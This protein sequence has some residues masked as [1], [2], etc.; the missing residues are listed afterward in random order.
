MTISTHLE[1]PLGELL[2]TSHGEKLTGLYFADSPHAPKIAPGWIE[3]EN[4]P[5]FAQVRLQIE[6]YAS[7]ERENFDLPVELAGTPFQMRVWREIS[8]IPFGETVTYGELARRA[9]SPGADRAAGTAAA[10]NPLCWIVPCHRVVAHDG[11]LAGYA[12][13]L[14]RKEALLAFESARASGLPVPLDFQPFAI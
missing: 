4:F 3:R 14:G 2:L 11:S 12:G 9:G 13:G 8:L 5:L 10:R 6:E 7:G 1:S